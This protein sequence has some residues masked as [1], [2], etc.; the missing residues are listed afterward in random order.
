MGVGS[1]DDEDDV[2]DGVGSDGGG[3]PS[4]K[5][6]VHDV[7]NPYGKLNVSAMKSANGEWGQ[8]HS[9]IVTCGSSDE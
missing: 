1:D 3:E 6:T 8:Y 7:V 9:R 2:D 4:K 5:E